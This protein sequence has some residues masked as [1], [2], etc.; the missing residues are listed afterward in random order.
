V[1]QIVTFDAIWSNEPSPHKD[2]G[3]A[4]R[5]FERTQLTQQEG[6]I[7]PT[8]H[9]H[10]ATARQGAALSPADRTSERNTTTPRA[11]TDA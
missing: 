10:G 2:D 8:K 9:R 11:A 3:L 7:L 1:K 6:R 5:R 4:A